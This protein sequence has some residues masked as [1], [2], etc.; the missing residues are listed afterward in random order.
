MFHNQLT[1]T[2]LHPPTNTLVENNTGSD[3]PILTAVAYNGM[4]TNFPSVV[5]GNGSAANVRGITIVDL[6]T[7]AS[8][9]VCTLG[10]AFNLNTSSW[11]N[12]TALYASSTGTLQTSPNGPRVATVYYQS[13]TAG[14]IYVENSYGGG[15]GGGTG[16]VVGPSSSTNQAIAV[17]DGTTGQLLKDGPGTEVQPSGAIVGQGFITDTNV[18][19]T[20]TVGAN[21]TWV[22]PGLNIESGGSIDLT[23]GGFLL[24]VG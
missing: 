19:G 10:F 21:Q 6:P 1:S 13:L 8:A 20:V 11:T 9:F 22:A 18:I 12:G 24:I 2:D 15:G 17:W 4:G 23:G 5:L 3:I 16:D 7:G 14:V